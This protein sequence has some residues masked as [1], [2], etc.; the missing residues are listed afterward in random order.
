MIIKYIPRQKGIYCNFCLSLLL[1]FCFFDLCFEDD[2]LSSSHTKDG[3]DCDL[4]K[5]AYRSIQILRKGFDTNFCFH[6]LVFILQ[7]SSYWFNN[8]LVRSI[9]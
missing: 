1:S 3:L 9:S 7:M 4:N 5:K 8:Y 2:G 6:K